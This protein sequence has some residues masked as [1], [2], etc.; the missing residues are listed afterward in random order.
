MQQVQNAE[1]AVADRDHR[2]AER[3]AIIAMLRELVLAR[4]SSTTAIMSRFTSIPDPPAFDSTRATYLTWRSQVQAK[5]R[6]NA[7]HF[8]SKTAKCNYV[9]SL[10]TGLASDHLRGSQDLATGEMRFSSSKEMLEFLDKRFGNPDP[11]G[12]VQQELEKLV[13]RLQVLFRVLQPI[14][15]MA[16]C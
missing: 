4:S 15:T 6:G 7:D 12:T 10:T 3:D 9:F 11:Q 5:L 14:R 8:L 1:E 2:L 16:G 13:A